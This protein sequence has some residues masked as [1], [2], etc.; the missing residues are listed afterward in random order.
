MAKVLILVEGQTEERFVKDILG[1]DLSAK[2]IWLIPTIITTKV[3][4][5]GPNNKGGTV[6]YEKIK[7]QIKNLANDSNSK[8]VTTMIDYYGVS[9]DF[10]G[11]PPQ[12]NDCYE[13][14]K[15]RESAFAKDIGLNKF[16][17]YLQLHEFEALLFS[18]PEKIGET[19]DQNI[20]NSLI[21]VRNNVRTPEEINDNPKTCPHE[22]I[23]SVYGKYNKPLYGL[24]I[25][26]RIGI[27]KIRQECP[28]FNEWINKLESLAR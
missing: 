8:M 26:K 23:E 17:P 4:Y 24:I 28:H 18:E 13:R 14:I 15:Y 11:N 5:N 27:K 25:A 3:V 16:L 7:K 10:P 2:G 12:G 21:N 20:A 1:P 6:K 9:D 22:R 19:L